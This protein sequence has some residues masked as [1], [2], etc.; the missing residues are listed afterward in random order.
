MELERLFNY[1]WK[2]YRKNISIVTIFSVLFL[3]AAIIP[4]FVALPTY[5]SLGGIYVRTESIPELS[6]V[7]IAVTLF[8]YLI[9]LFIIAEAVVNINLI[10]KSKRTSVP[11]PSQMIKN[12]G[13]Y[14]VKVFLALVILEL[15][16]FAIQLLLFDK[17]FNTLIYPIAVGIISFLFFYIAP[18]IVIDESNIFNAIV[19]SSNHAM[20]KPQMIIVWAIIG[21]VVLS[22]VKLIFDLIL[23]NFSA[24]L[25]LLVNSLFVLPYLLILQTQMY[26]E[27]Y[28]LAR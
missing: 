18:A 25:V 17:P 24:Y 3:M 26:M 12:M 16:I 27:K 10:I 15:L 13:R 22:L 14:T 19:R 23:P 20:K 7:D 11:I 8:V 28:P 9:S 6:L 4:L 2:F 5:M 21:F 1:S